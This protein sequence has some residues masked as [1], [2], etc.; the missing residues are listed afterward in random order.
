MS[1]ATFSRAASTAEKAAAAGTATSRGC[2]QGRG[3]ARGHIDLS[4]KIKDLV[5]NDDIVAHRNYT[6]SRGGSYGGMRGGRGV[7][8]RGQWRG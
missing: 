8:H 1:S 3:W 7:S 2:W 6:N 5:S 4:T